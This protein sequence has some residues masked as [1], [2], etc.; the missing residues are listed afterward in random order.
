MSTENL[1]K[2][3]LAPHV[4][5]KSAGRDRQYVFKVVAGANKLTIKKAV[6]MFFSVK[7]KNVR[8]LNNKGKPA[9]FGRTIGRHKAWKKA[10]V[11]LTEGQHIEIGGM[12]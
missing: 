2:V 7:V 6:E 10:Y 4:S 9:R 3:L 5:E 11:T 12:Q 8:T 1:F